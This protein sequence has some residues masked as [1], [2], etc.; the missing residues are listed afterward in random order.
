MVMD[1][2]FANQALGLEWLR[3][4]VDDLEPKVY[5]IPEEIDREVA[6]LKLLTY[7]IAIDTLTEEQSRYLSSWDQGS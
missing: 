1:M 7:G 5:G 3:A 4:H 6:R 2:S